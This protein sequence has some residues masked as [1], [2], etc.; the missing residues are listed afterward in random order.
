MIPMSRPII[1][2][3]D[4]ARILEVL[5]SGQLAAGRFAGELEQAL[6]AYTGRKFAIVTSSGTAALCAAVLAAGWGKGD[7]VITTPFT[8]IATVNALI[9]AGVTPVF[10]DIDPR[11]FN[12]SPRAVAQSLRRHPRCKGIVA[13]NL[14][15]LPADMESLA[16]LAGEWGL[17]TIEDCAQ[18]PGAAIGVRKAGSFGDLATLSF[19]ATSNMTTGEGG[20]VLTDDPL[21][22]GR[23]RRFINHG[24]QSRGVHETIGFNFRMTDFQA[25]LGIGQLSRLDSLN[26]ACRANAAFYDANLL[27]NWFERPWV[28]QGYRHVYHHYTLKVQPG[29]RERFCRHLDEQ[30]VGY[31]ID[32]PTTAYQQP[33]YRRIPAVVEGCPAAED[34]AL[35]VVSIPVHPALSRDELARVVEVINSYRPHDK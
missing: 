14:Y 17:V 15:G 28:P 18:A 31:A 21:L 26:D 23:V 32:Y 8:F 3:E 2:A 35:R 30:G 4:K 9:L 24:Q 13:V 1:T 6:A 20:A 22:A 12:L 11:T 5:D 7:H 29:E 33:A 16:A 34:A 10:V 19:G 27:G 25:A